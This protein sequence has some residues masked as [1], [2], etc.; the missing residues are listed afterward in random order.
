[1]NIGPAR[2]QER[3]KKDAAVTALVL[4]VV[5]GVDEVRDAREARHEAEAQRPET[6]TISLV[7]IKRKG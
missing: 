2:P 1:M 5:E 7:A 6:L 3:R 4:H